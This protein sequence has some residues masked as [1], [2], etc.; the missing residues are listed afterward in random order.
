MTHG[1]LRSGLFSFQACGDVPVTFLSLI[2]TLIPLWLL[3]TLCMISILSGLLSLVRGPDVVYRALCP[4]LPERNVCT[5]A[6]VC[7]VEVGHSC[8]LRAIEIFGILANSASS[9]LSVVGE[10]GWKCSPVLVKVSFSPLSY[11]GFCFTH[12]TALLS[13]AHTFTMA[14]CSW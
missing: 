7:S 6:A 4:V 1:L 13:D 3:N 12:F 9:C 10:R 2:S 8:W 14:V 5:A 11:I